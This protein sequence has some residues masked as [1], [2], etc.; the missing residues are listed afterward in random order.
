MRP[1]FR[2]IVLREMGIVSA[3]SER[4][5]EVGGVELWIVQARAGDREALGR[6]LDVCRN[7]LLLIANQELAPAL[8][9]K[10]A[11]SDIVQE[12]LLEAGRDFPRFQGGSEEELL[13]W[14]RGILRNNLANL[15]RHYDTEKRQVDRE[16]PLEELHEPIV[17]Q[18]ET[19]S[20]QASARERDEKLENALRMLPEHYRQ[21]IVW[22]STDGLTFVQIAERLGSNAG[23]VRKL[24]G[25]A[26]ESLAKLLEM[27]NDST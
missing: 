3:E 16:L 5:R 22:H 13:A 26:V 23:A 2:D 21:V 15:H 8:W 20:A 18:V 7:Y 17:D 19:P 27:P 4:P 24:W 12:S 25:R 11:P 9:A 14:L 10:I 6:L 1:V